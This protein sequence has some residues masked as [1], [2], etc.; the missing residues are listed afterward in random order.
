ML[1]LANS[2]TI[3]INTDKKKFSHDRTLM[4]LKIHAIFDTLDSN[5]EGLRCKKTSRSS[6][7][8]GY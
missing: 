2:H 1:I 3:T 6:H 5:I 8:H 4:Y 7:K